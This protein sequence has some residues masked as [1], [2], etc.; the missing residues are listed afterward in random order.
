MV[1]SYRCPKCGIF[2]SLKM[3]GAE[4]PVCGRKGIRQFDSATHYKPTKG[5]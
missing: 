4:C 5:R 3:R 1:Y 2:V